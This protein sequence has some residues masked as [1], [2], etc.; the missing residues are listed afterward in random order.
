LFG[1]FAY[2]QLF[3]LL[4]F[5]RTTLLELVEVKGNTYSSTTLCIRYEK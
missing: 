5:Q 3:Q 2:I 1:L 4:F